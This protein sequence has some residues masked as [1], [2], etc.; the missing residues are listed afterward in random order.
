MSSLNES[1]HEAVAER[2]AGQLKSLIIS[3][4]FTILSSSVDDEDQN[5]GAFIAEI[6]TIEA[7]IVFSTDSI[8]RSF[9]EG[10]KDPTVEDESID[11][12]LIDGPSLLEYLPDDYGVLLDAESEHALII[13]PDLI[14]EIKNHA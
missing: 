7:L 10:I 1:I 5:V 9:V 2:D 3:G 6:D 4:E 12:I 13:E 8:A 11:G 14:R